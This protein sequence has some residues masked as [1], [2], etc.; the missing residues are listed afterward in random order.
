MKIAVN[1][2][3]DKLRITDISSSE[4]HE[5]GEDINIS[6]EEILE[7]NV[8]SSGTVSAGDQEDHVDE[9]GVEQ[10]PIF[11]PDDDELVDDSL[12]RDIIQ[13]EKIDQLNQNG[14]DTAV[15]SNGENGNSIKSKTVKILE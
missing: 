8:T 11:V 10:E 5:T 15:S 4:A 12:F 6:T 2:I 9:V 7:D 3:V 1:Y 14:A 13:D